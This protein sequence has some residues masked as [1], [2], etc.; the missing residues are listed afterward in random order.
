MFTTHIY[1][2]ATTD[3]NHSSIN[4]TD[5][6]LQDEYFKV[7]FDLKEANKDGHFAEKVCV[8]V[9]L[10]GFISVLNEMLLFC[11]ML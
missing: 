9:F 6:F 7:D 11:R 4:K 3:V 8:C 5:Y 1:I 10:F 2:S